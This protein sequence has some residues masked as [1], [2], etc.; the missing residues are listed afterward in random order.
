MIEDD[1]CTLIRIKS[2][3]HH[4]HHPIKKGIVTIPHPVK[5]IDP[6]TANSIKRQAGLK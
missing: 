2:S 3:H 1:G 4:F 6:K 5:D